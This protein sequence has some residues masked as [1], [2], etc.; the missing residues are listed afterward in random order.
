MESRNSSNIRVL[1]K[2]FQALLEGKAETRSKTDGKENE[3]KKAEKEWYKL[4]GE[5][6]IV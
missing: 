2:A 4:W 3:S 6:K 5:V 1:V